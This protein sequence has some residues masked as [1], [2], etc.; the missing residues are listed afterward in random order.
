MLEIAA[1]LYGNIVCEAKTVS[2]TNQVMCLILS[3]GCR[4]DK[5]FETKLSG[6]LMNKMSNKNEKT[7]EME[8]DIDSGSFGFSLSL[9]KSHSSSVAPGSSLNEDLSIVI[10]TIEEVESLVR[11]LTGFA[12]ND[13]AESFKSITLVYMIGTYCKQ[14]NDQKLQEFVKTKERDLFCL[15]ALEL[16]QC[17][18]IAKEELHGVSDTSRIFLKLAIQACIRNEPRDYS[19]LGQIFNEIIESS[20]SRSHA[21][22]YIEEF[23]QMLK[24][25]SPFS[26]DDIDA[27]AKLSYN[28]GITLMELQHTDLAEKF[29]SLSLSLSKHTSESFKLSNIES[30][31]DAYK[32]LLEQIQ[33]EKEQN[34]R[35]S[36]I[37]DIIGGGMSIYDK[38]LYKNTD[39]ERDAA[40]TLAFLQ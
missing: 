16:Q 22:Q 35:S 20:P 10:K 5:H 23:E 11:S 12:D 25:D 7:T 36:G 38:S 29:I 37:S 17:A 28:H 19:L 34:H 15:T 21:L 31:Q 32:Y 4:L 14:Q 40:L 24:T 33:Q 13:F 2:V 9:E 30:M 26:V 39:K 6:A 27:I 3:C 1:K 18:T 8:A